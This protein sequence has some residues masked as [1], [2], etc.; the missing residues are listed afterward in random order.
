MSTP[1]SFQRQDGGG[2]SG[3]SFQGQN[4][5]GSGLGFS[6][7]VSPAVQVAAAVGALARSNRFVR[8]DAPDL[9]QNLLGRYG[10]TEKL[11]LRQYSGQAW[12]TWNVSRPTILRPLTQCNGV[13]AYS[14]IAKPSTYG[15][16]LDFHQ[17]IHAFGPGLCYLHSPGD[18]H[19]WY[20]G[21]AGTSVPVL[22]IACEDPVLAAS[23]LSDPGFQ[24][25]S[26]T[27]FTTS[28]IAS[29]PELLITGN[30]FRRGLIIT[31]AGPAAQFNLSL[32]G[33]AG[34]PLPSSLSGSQLGL[35]IAGVGSSV[36]LTGATNWRGAVY[37]SSNLG[38]SNLTITE[39]M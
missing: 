32:V 28:A 14:P 22:Q 10:E 24:L 9:D 12:E 38:S 19:V 6:G 36:S 16:L 30:R 25:V 18:W 5:V 33:P 35:Q 17:A 39:Y 7:N 2:S 26:N 15:T 3:T 11:N 8:T 37:V 20:N 31:G 21:P 4:G 23:M 1:L 34:V 29:T 13:V 27:R